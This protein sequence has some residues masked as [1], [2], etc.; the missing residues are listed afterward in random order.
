MKKLLLG[1]G[2]VALAVT[3][4]RS[5]SGSRHE[6]KSLLVDR[7]WIER[8]PHGETD[9][10]HALVMM[11]D[12]AHGLFVEASL[13]KSLTEGFVFELA[14]SELRTTFPQSGSKE[15]FKVDAHAC[16]ENGFEVCLEMAGGA[17]GVQRYYSMKDWVIDSQ[18]GAEAKLSKLTHP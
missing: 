12:H 15:T 2:I 11:T 1:V 7:I 5:H 18:A 14:G 3:G 9:T 17:H 10:I 6:S 13:W 8:M 16:T 4:W